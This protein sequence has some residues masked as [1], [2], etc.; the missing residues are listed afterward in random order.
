MKVAADIDYELQP[1]A[2]LQVGTDIVNPRSVRTLVSLEVEDL[3]V[4]ERRVPLG[5]CVGIPIADPEPDL[6]RQRA[7]PAPPAR[8][9]PRSR[10]PILGGARCRARAE[11]PSCYAR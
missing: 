11:G 5:G 1:L 7:G 3:A 6:R 2:E 10:A 4:G 8:D 9:L